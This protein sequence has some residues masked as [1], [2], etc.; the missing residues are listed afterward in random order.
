MTDTTPTGPAPLTVDVAA[1]P[2]IAFSPGTVRVQSGGT[3]RFV[4]GSVAHNVF[5]DNGPAGA[6]ANIA[7]SNAN[8]N[9][10]LTF[11]TVGSF[12]YNCHIHPGMQGT[13]VVVT[14]GTSASGN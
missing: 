14:P 9:A 13:V 12:V 7:G 5:F 4:F 6:P 2:S 8:V 1:T 11:S 3:V 10:T